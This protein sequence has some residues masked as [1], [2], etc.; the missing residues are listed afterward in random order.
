M[1]ANDSPEIRVAVAGVGN[2]ASSLVE[3]TCYYRQHP[4][5]DAG[6]LFPSLAG[7]TVRDI[8]IVAAFDISR[9][10]VG[11]PVR[12]AIYQPPN[13]FFRIPGC[14]R[15]RFRPGPARAHAGRKPGTPRH[16]W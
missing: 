10:K 7:Y 5:T 14:F 3:G 6:L 16:A 2:C 11:L 12:E 1:V 9:S 4:D 15:G 13:N 8:G